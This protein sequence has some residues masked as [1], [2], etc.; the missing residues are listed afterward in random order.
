MEVQ[1]HTPL[2][3]PEGW[4]RYE[5][6]RQRARFS[7]SA[8]KRSLTGSTYS[9]RV[10]LSPSKAI[11][12]LVTELERL[13]AWDAHLYTNVFKRTKTRTIESDDPGAALYFILNEEAHVLACDKWTRVADNIA[14]IAGH[15]W[16]MRAQDRYGVGT[17][18]R[19]FAGYRTAIPASIDRA[20]W[21]DVLGVKGG[22]TWEEVK[23]AYA[24]MLR[25]CHPD[26]GGT[27]EK[28]EEVREALAD[29][30]REMLV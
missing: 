21:R 12:R 16:T 7:G 30:K 1:L 27:R 15:I 9:A 26:H 4:D 24:E 18:R 13:N 3:W 10:P 25:L 6:A 20:P 19:A 17:Q 23:R 2:K 5:E 11:T 29:A 8:E 22:C 14:A 28:M